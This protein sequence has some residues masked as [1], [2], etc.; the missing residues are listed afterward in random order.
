[1][2]ALQG[3]EETMLI[4]L[5][6]KANETLR[7][8]ARIQ[9][10]K[11]VEIVQKLQLDT[12]K[13]DKFMSHEGVVARTILFDKAFNA[14]LKKI[15]NAACIC[16][17]CGLDARFER[18]DN[19]Q[20]LWYDLDLP[21]VIAI[22]KK[23]FQQAPRVFTIAKS[24]FDPS[25]TEEVEKGRPTIFMMEGVLMYFTEEQ[26]RKL[27]NM[28]CEKFPKSIF[29]LELSPP[30]LKKFGKHHDTVKN[31]T[32]TF[33][34]GVETAK[35]LEGYVKGLKLVEEKSFHCEMKKYSLRG[36]LFAALPFTKN[37]NNR[38]AIYQYKK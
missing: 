25:W 20:I 24:V 15:P 38:L 3:V 34:W 10:K 4:P 5:S 16:I 32:A 17:G 8:N 9:D 21:N 14:I 35:E 22:R 31:T 6:I 27:L 1:M 11:A 12:T 36:K 23:Y 37:L 29:L 18:V 33:Q 2:A 30:F 26:I 19:G 13:Y 7:S 28:L